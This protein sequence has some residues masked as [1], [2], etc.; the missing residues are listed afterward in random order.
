MK[1]SLFLFFLSLSVLMTFAQVNVSGVVLDAKTSEPI[2]GASVQVVGTTNGTITDFD[3]RFILS[4]ASA[5]DFL[6][7]AYLGYEKRRVSANQASHVLLSE[8]SKALEEVVVVGY[9]VQKKSVVTA[10]ISK[11]TSEELENLLPTR[12]DN[13]LEGKASGVTVTTTSGQ[14]GAGSRIHIRGI[15]TIN[16]ASPLYVVDG[17]PMG[18]I[19]FINPSDIASMEVLKDAASAAIYGSKGANGVI[20]V[21]TKNGKMGDKVSVSYNM[22]YGWQN[23]WKQKAVLNGPWYQTILN[24]ARLNDG[25]EPYFTTITKE[26]G[27]NW[28]NELFNY[29]A[30][31]QSH[32]VNVQGGSQRVSYFVSFGYF[33]QD[34]IV[35]G[36]Y[37]RSNYNRI[38]VRNNN[39]YKIMDTDKRKWLNR[40]TLTSNINYSNV[41]STGIA[42]N[43]AFYS[44]LGSALLI[45]PTQPVYATNP[46]EVLS[47]YPTAV[48]DKNGRVYSIPDITMSEVINPIANL[49]LP[50]GWN[51]S[52]RF[53]GN[54]TGEL[55][56]YE[57]L[58]WKTNFNADFNF[59][60]SD[61]Y[62]Y[63]FYLSSGGAGSSTNSS[64][65]S[66]QS[67]TWTWQV[68]NTLSYSH[69]FKSGHD[70]SVLLGQ[71]ATKVSYSYVSGMDY[72]LP[73]YDS[74]KATI[75]YAQGDQKDE[76]VGGGRSYSA[77]AS[78]FARVNYNYKERYLF[79]ASV[80]CD[81][82]DKFGKNNRWGWFPS[83]SL[84]WNIAREDFWERVPDWFSAFKVRGSWGL[85]GNDRISD[86]A[87]TSL[88][89]SGSNYT[90]GKGETEAIITGVRQGRLANQNL[91]W[92]TSNQTDV[93]LELGFLSNALTFNFDFFHKTTKDMLMPALLPSYIGIEQPWTNGGKMLNWGVEMDLNYKF[94]A[95]PVNFDIGGNVSYLK[96]K[97]IDYGNE[98]G[99]SNLDNIQGVGVASRAENGEVY[100]F[101]YGYKTDG[102]FQTQSEVNSYTNSKGQLLQ[103][104]AHPGDVRFVDA[105]GDGSIDD[106][107]RVKIG[108]GMPDVTYA[109]HL[110]VEWEGV[111][112]CLFFTGIA[113]NQIYD[114]TRRPDLS[115][116]NQPAWMINR[117]T[118]P[119]TST[120]IPR[121]TEQDP[122]DNWRSS[123]LYIKDGAYCR[124]KTLQLGYSIPRKWIS[125]I[126][127]QK[128]KVFFLAENLI[129]FTKYDGFDPEIGSGGTSIGID[130][131]CYPQS[132]TL[133][134]GL[135]ITL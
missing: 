89:V 15:G 10:A 58:V 105:N 134:V 88:I 111:E 48:R 76:R 2:I 107:D 80:R 131:G 24:E 74:Y 29:N 127:L 18:S 30:P 19:D 128:I 87:Y 124:L 92:E 108:K 129:T 17:M 115:L 79:Q 73:S 117:W 4:V 62:S 68:E 11:V 110:N 39:V 9:G 14:P 118:G 84:G 42:E 126:R 21:T 20:L 50:G 98:T 97:L 56:I 71:S 99:S 104:N 25:S 75:D 49:Q 135:N 93:G 54:F 90:F 96:N 47:K 27:T 28:Q 130:M 23:P 46:E 103:P 13:M 106:K 52:D 31:V 77:G 33:G 70:L 133:S 35:G 116:S 41:K 37:K 12:A 3:G 61:S 34:G 83:F 51:Y 43:S 65:S 55:Q 78:Y 114:A 72:N 102:I 120:K 101:F 5:E 109:A 100:P 66:S 38:S 113:G 125:R 122:N 36:N 81:G 82:S 44:P 6:E 22:T 59:G 67:R 40:F 94:K 91:K 7:F 32:Q 86:F 112:L 119:G 16:D 121:M 64:V 8:E 69:Q 95:G 53:I 60:R 1:K 85:N 132:R 123:D 63:P 57:G 45:D 26:A